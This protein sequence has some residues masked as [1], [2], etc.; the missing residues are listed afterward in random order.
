MCDV[1]VGARL[2]VT[3][4]LVV[5]PVRRPAGYCVPSEQIQLEDEG[6]DPGGPEK[7]SKNTGIKPGR[8]G[9]V[10]AVLKSRER[11]G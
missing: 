4:V 7:S 11:M 5:S 8:L 3:L 9:L 1:D 2:G 6:S 10:E